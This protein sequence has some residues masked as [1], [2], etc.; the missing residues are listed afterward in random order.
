M[1]LS[2]TSDSR[3]AGF[4][5]I[6]LIVTMSILSII[7]VMA[8]QVTESA[9]NSIRLTES[10]SSNDAVARE[11]FERINRDLSQMV[12]R[13]DARVEFKS[14]S[15]NDAFAFLTCSKGFTA[16][17][18]VGDRGVSLVSYA[19][20]HDVTLGGKLVRGSRGHLF[21]DVASDALK[22]DNSIPFPTIVPDNL[23][24]L[25]YNV[26]RFEVEYLVQGST[27]V[28]IEVTPPATTD[29]LRGLVITLVTLDDR[30]RRAIKPDRL[31]DLANRFPDAAN[32][33]N[34]LKTWSRKRDDMAKSGIPGLQKDV[35]QSIRCYQRTF[36]IP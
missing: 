9:R 26:I 5:L 24:T 14:K 7:L 2:S 1:N 22:L 33:E 35:L 4:T 10:K 23:Q 18:A 28:T 34:T 11:T 27:G 36:L 13:K 32:G 31:D 16:A 19:L 6:E 17:G 25:T 29:N 30:G 20:L 3:R 15:G 8:L 21:G 12:V